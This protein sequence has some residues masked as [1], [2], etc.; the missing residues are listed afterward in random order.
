[1]PDTLMRP[2]GRPCGGRARQRRR[3]LSLARAA[4]AQFGAAVE[5]EITYRRRK[6]LRNPRGLFWCSPSLP[7]SPVPLV[8]RKPFPPKA[9][10]H[11]VAAMPEGRFQ[12]GQP[13]RDCAEPQSP[14]GGYA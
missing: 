8:W 3:N 11:R 1:M 13:E 2:A 10:E 4:S 7:S 12:S 14:K 5:S 6:S 9:P